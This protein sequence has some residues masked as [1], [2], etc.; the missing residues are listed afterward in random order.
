MPQKFPKTRGVEIFTVAVGDPEA[1]REDRVDVKT[2]QEIAE[3][4][5]RQIFLCRDASALSQV[6]EQIAEFDAPFS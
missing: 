4:T 6:Y 3:R 2:L 1:T 5:G